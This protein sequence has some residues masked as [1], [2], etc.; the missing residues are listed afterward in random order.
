MPDNGWGIV[1]GVLLVVGLFNFG[2]MRSMLRN[3]GKRAG[4]LPGSISELL[5]PWQKEDQ[6]L[7][8]LH[9]QV[10][11]LDVTQED[12]QPDGVNG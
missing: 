10:K 7:E 5:F 9:Q 2:L 3:Q 6:A 4:F 11:D 12:Q 8:K 1:C